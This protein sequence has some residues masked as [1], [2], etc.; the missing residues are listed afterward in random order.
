MPAII[1]PDPPPQTTVPGNYPMGR[2]LSPDARDHQYRA[3]SMQPRALGEPV[4][5]RKQ[6][7]FLPP[8]KGNWRDQG[9]E[10]SCT[11]HALTNKLCGWPMPRPLREI[12]WQHHAL[13][14][15]AQ[16]IDEWPGEEPRYYGT[17]ARAVCRAAREFGLITEWWNAFTVD[18]VLDLLLA[19]NADWNTCGPVMIGVNW[20]E[21]MMSTVDGYVVPGG[22]I[23]GGHE[24]LFLGA[25]L[26]TETFYG[27]NSWLTMRLFRIR[28][29]HFE[30]LL[31][32]NGDAVFPV[33]APRP[34]TRPA[35]TPEVEVA[36]V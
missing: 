8:A 30:R 12:P 34:G 3:S 32:E 15:R 11:E 4:R 23:V 1:L 17:S 29:K 36:T 19:D 18:E 14:R 35:S 20:Y 33:E 25:N 26:N 7:Y 2:L 13:Y 21:G 27:I 28:F 16:Q 31:R 5:R 24:V 22:R 6:R 10:Q 9:T